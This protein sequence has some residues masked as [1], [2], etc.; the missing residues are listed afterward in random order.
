[1]AYRSPLPHYYLARIYEANGQRK[2]AHEQWEACLRLIDPGWSGKM[3]WRIE[4]RE[5]LEQLK[6]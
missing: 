6:E 2:A 5:R 3:E 4:A 1:V